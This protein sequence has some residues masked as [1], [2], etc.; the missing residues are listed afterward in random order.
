MREILLK[1]IEQRDDSQYTVHKQNNQTEDITQSAQDCNKKIKLKKL[2]IVR[3]L[4]T[5][6][7]TKEI[8]QRARDTNEI[9]GLKR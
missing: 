3:I 7:Q 1:T 9:S 8:T 5:N 2:L 6:N 4:L